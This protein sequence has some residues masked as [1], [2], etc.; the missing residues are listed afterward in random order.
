MK[1]FVLLGLVLGA[2]ASCGDNLKPGGTS[3]TTDAATAID[4]TATDGQ[5]GPDAMEIDAAPPADQ[6][7]GSVAFLELAALNPG[8]VTAGAE[9]F[10]QGLAALITVVDNDVVPGPILDTEPGLPTGCKLW[11][12]DTPAEIAGAVVG[13]DEGAFQLSVTG[14]TAPATPP[15]IPACIWQAGI[16]YS[17]PDTTTLTTGGAIAVIGGG[18][19][20][21]TTTVAYNDSVLGR[22]VLIRGALTPSN[23]GLF[24]IVGRPTTNTIRYANAGAALEAVLPGASSSVVVGA[25]GPIPQVP[26]PGFL[27]NDAVPGLEHSMGAHIPTFTANGSNTLLAG[28]GDDFSMHADPAANAT[29]LTKLNNIP[30]DGTAFT[31]SCDAAVCG[32]ALGSI[33]TITTTDATPQAGN[34]FSFPTSTGKRVEIRCAA[35]GATSVTIPANFMQHVMTSGAKRIRT[36]FTRGNLI[37]SSPTAPVT[38]LVGHSIAGFTNPPP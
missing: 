30:L 27:A 6:F 10:G 13:V 14:G 38:V 15:T 25:A 20:S 17:C 31:V 29:E 26:D 18:V 12:Y 28:V 5:Q 21:L 2:A 1:R 35:I 16:G 11:E 34:P 8:T 7:T 4:A 33:M 22:Y 36:I 23:N 37:N 3:G 19:A 24:P 32:A 9:F